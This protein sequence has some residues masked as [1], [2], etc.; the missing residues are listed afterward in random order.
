MS[1]VA[2]SSLLPLVA[3]ATLADTGGLLVDVRSSGA[4][5]DPDDA[6]A[7]INVRTQG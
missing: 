2:V 6:L 4:P 3:S 5:V 7:T 1:A